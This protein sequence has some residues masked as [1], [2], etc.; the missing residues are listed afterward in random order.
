[1]SDTPRNDIDNA[2]QKPGHLSSRL[3]HDGRVVHL[4]VDEVRFPDGSTGELE[5]VRHKG[6]SAIVPLKRGKRNGESIVILIRQFRY[7]AGGY[8]YEIPAGIPEEGEG[9]EDCAL[10]ELEEETGLKADGLRHLT[11]IFTTPGFTDEVIHLFLAQDL[12]EGDVRRDEDEFMEVVEVP[13]PRV[14]EMIREGEIR[15]G[16]SIVALLFVD[17]FL[18]EPSQNGSGVST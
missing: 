4:S 14:L 13:F 5:L 8:I 11:R 9:W 16:K 2:G 12:R 15:D 7:A 18:R 10:R 17:R 6:A 1:M 3:I